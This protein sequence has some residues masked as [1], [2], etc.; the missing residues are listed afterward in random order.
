MHYEVWGREARTQNNFFNANRE[1][2]PI[3]AHTHSNSITQSQSGVTHASATASQ[4]RVMAQ[5]NIFSTIVPEEIA[6][7]LCTSSSDYSADD[8][9]GESSNSVLQ[10]PR[11]R[12]AAVL[13]YDN[14]SQKTRKLSS[15]NLSA[16][17]P[18]SLATAQLL[19]GIQSNVLIIAKSGKK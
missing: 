7:Q 19:G 1:Q 6:K 9:D 11:K 15:A 18:G 12:P 8:G 2:W 5:Q 14:D 13:V 16:T 4:R 17:E 3:T 10:C